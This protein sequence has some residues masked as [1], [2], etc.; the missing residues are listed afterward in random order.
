MAKSLNETVISSNEPARKGRTQGARRREG[1]GR[2]KRKKKGSARG[3]MSGS[4][5]KGSR[6]VGLVQK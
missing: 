4:E 1:R 5:D 3:R 2:E 6:G